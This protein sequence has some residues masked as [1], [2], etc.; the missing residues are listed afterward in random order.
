MRL[1]GA[2]LLGISI[3]LPLLNQFWVGLRE[4]PTV[5]V[6]K[7]NV[8]GCPEGINGLDVDPGCKGLSSAAILIVINRSESAV[9][10]VGAP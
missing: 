7:E 8:R 1:L 3:V 4:H 10:S 9:L 6:A 2:A 5:H